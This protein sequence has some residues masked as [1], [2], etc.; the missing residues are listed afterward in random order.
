MT[1]TATAIVESSVLDKIAGLLQ[2]AEKNN[3]VHESAAA[4]AAAQALLTKHRLTKADLSEHTAE[5]TEA[6]GVAESPLFSGNRQVAW[7]VDLASAVVNTNGCRMYFARQYEGYSVARARYQ[8]GVKLVGRDSDIQIVRYFFEYLSR[9]I[10]RL[11][12]VGVANGELRGKTACNS[13]KMGAMRAVTSRLYEG[14]RESRKEA[15]KALTAGTSTAIVKLDSADAEVAEYYKGLNLG[16]GKARQSVRLD[17]RAY[18]AGQAAGRGIA[19]NKGL[20]G[21]AAPKALAG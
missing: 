9:E 11:C 18:N 2:L 14:H 8:I 16:K 10:E 17:G 21:K 19:L 13:F 7:R 3:N 15:E 4:A 20:G 1:A 12:E 6:V 5:K